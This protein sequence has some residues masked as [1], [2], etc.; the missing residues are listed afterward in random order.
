MKISSFPCPFS[1]LKTSTEEYEKRLSRK[2]KPFR[3]G[4]EGDV[5]LNPRLMKTTKIAYITV[6]DTAQAIKSTD[7]NFHSVPLGSMKFGFGLGFQKNSAY[8][9]V[10]SNQY[11][12]PIV[13]KRKIKNYIYFS[14]FTFVSKIY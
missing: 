2:L 7:C 12:A 9:E 14:N 8:T 3:R 4:S 1:F 6:A 5:G 13:T 10:F 11:V